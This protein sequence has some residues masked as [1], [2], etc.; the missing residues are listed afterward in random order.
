[1][2]SVRDL[3]HAMRHV[4]TTV[5]DQA[6]RTTGCIQRQR[7]LSGATLC[8]TLVLGWLAKPAATLDALCQMAAACGVRIT[9]QGL[10]QRFTPK[11]AALLKQVLD[12]AIEQ[13]LG[14]D[15]VA[16]PLL[17]RFAGVYLQDCST[18]TLPAALAELWPGCGDATETGHTAVLKLGVRLDL[19]QGLVQG[20][21]LAAGK[22]HDR[23]VAQRLPLL[24]PG[25]LRLADLGFFCLPELAAQ[26]AA[27]C[28]WLTRVQTGTVLF[29]ATG[30]RWELL[31]L[32]EAVGA[33]VIDR[34]IRLGASQ[35]LACRLVATRVPEAVANQ[36]RRRMKEEARRRGK[37]VTADRLRLAGW[38][39]LVTNVPP[40]LLAVH[41]AFVLARARWQ[42]EL[43]FKLWKSTGGLTTWRSDQPWRILCELYAKL[44]AMVVQQWLLL[45]T[46]WRA[47]DRSLVKASAAV[48]TWAPALALALRRP[49]RLPQVLRDLADPLRAGCRINRRRAKPNTYQLLTDPFLSYEWSHAA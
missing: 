21:V 32:L 25:S 34:P 42:I 44:I 8:Q 40:A 6:G 37:G 49:A 24:P 35:R 38:T 28:F 31:Q 18:I 4:L 12:A 47:P 14:T 9:P 29:D 5:A 33:G 10:D 26:D 46:C 22:A 15:P 43:L 11:L 13:V 19:G 17:R 2:L 3:S 39:V 41:E 20:P 27:G 1:M 48:R 30:R 36:R 23:T 7:K 45:T 16:I